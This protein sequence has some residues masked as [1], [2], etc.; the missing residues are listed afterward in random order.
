LGTLALLRFLD[1][2]VGIIWRDEVIKIFF[3]HSLLCRVVEPELVFRVFQCHPSAL[4]GSSLPSIVC[5]G[6]EDVVFVI[7]VVG[8]GVVYRFLHL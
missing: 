4:G 2:F 7:V 1:V 6:L 8:F 5:D 3:D